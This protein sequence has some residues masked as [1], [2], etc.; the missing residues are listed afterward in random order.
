MS[1]RTIYALFPVISV[2]FPSGCGSDGG[3]GS[4]KPGR[5]RNAVFAGFSETVFAT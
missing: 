4:G 1:R 3:S 5:K 2:V